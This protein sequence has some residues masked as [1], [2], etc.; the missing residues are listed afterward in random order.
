MEK[1]YDYKKAEK[2]VPSFKV[3]LLL[4][5]L[6]EEACYN[7]MDG[8]PLIICACKVLEAL[9][10][11]DGSE[12]ETESKDGTVTKH[13]MFIATKELRELLTSLGMLDD[14]I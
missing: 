14:F 10:L 3:D 4:E 12:W 1:Y 2:S 8:A 13:Y 11:A 7:D 6:L 5:K 9:E